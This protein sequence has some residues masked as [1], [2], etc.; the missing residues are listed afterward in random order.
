[1]MATQHF[2]LKGITKSFFNYLFKHYEQNTNT[3]FPNKNVITLQYDIANSFNS[4]EIIFQWILII[5]YN[6]WSY[7]NWIQCL[8]YPGSKCRLADLLGYSN[9]HVKT[10]SLWHFCPW[11]DLTRGR[12]RQHCQNS[13][14]NLHHSHPA[15]HTS[16]KVNNVNTVNDQ[17]STIWNLGSLVFKT[18]HC[19]TIIHY[20]TF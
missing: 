19:Y 3:Y 1:M 4:Q 15:I 8:P 12:T 5:L 18:F 9:G 17:K 16:V 2:L 11:P 10:Q 14:A 20:F 6:V 13:S 7:D